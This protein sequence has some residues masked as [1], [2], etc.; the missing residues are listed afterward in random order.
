MVIGKYG[1]RRYGGAPILLLPLLAVAVAGVFAEVSPQKRVQESVQEP[2]RADVPTTDSLTFEQLYEPEFLP[3]VYYTEGVKLEAEENY[4][5]ALEMFVKATS[6]DP[7]HAPSL[8]ETA[9]IMMMLGDLDKALEYSTRA[10]ALDPDNIW[11]RGQ[12]ARLLVYRERYDEA[13]PLFESMLGRSHLFDPDNYR[14]LSVLYHKQGRVDDAIAI[15][16]SA[17]VRLGRSP[18]AINLKRSILIDAGRV[19]EAVAVTEAYVAATP[20]DEENRLVLADL[21]GYLHK[22]SMQVAMLREVLEVNP[23]NV[24]ALV[25]LSDYYLDRGS[26]GLYL[27]TLKQLFLLDE[28][29]LKSK[30]DYLRGLMARRLTFYRHHFAEVNDLALTLVTH[31]PGD[32]EVMKLYADHMIGSGDIE[33]ALTMFKTLLDRPDP[34]LEDYLQVIDIEAYLKRQDSVALYSDRALARFPCEHRIYMMKSGALQ[35]MGRTKE[36]RKVLEKALKTAGADSLRSEVLGSL[37]TLWHEDGNLKKTYDYYEKALKYD[38]NNHHVLNNYAYFLAVEGKQLDRA[39]GM[40]SRAVK[41]QE[42]SPTYLDTYAWVLYRQGNYAE[43]KKIMQ[44]ALP[45]DRSNSPEL[46]IHYGDILRVL[47]E[48]FMASVYWKRARDAGYEPVSAIEERLS[49]L[50]A[51]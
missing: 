27:A 22:D 30:L 19:D 24:T 50:D 13:L 16:D 1:T 5:E 39:L 6:L 21:Y 37:G 40:A 44:Q 3:T 31:Y 10:A 25:N 11:Y 43:A 9:N 35:H 26:T 32:P 36:A 47:G 49:G 23:D 41:L 34:Q 15:L 28:V 51:K 14:I 17:E 48:N 29:P 12:M 4:T 38:P 2:V 45:L 46:L 20:Y 7:D 18:E 8:Y 42:N 33:G